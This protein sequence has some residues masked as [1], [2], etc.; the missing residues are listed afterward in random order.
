MGVVCYRY[1]KTDGEVRLIQ[2]QEKI[3]KV[4]C[5]TYKAEIIQKPEIGKD[6]FRIKINAQHNGD[7]PCEKQLLLLTFNFPVNFISCTYGKLISANN[8][9]RIRVILT[10]HNNPK[11]KIEI[12]YF[13][14]CSHQ[15]LEIV[16]CSINDNF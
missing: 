5:Y 2:H 3:V 12:D 16:N 6:D 1:R 15:D 7:H 8:T 9:T 14:K 4:N 13:L 10:Y 11:D